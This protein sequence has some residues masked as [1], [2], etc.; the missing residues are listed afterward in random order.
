MNERMGEFGGGFQGR[1]KQNCSREI[2]VK[3]VESKGIAGDYQE[4]KV[5]RQEPKL[6][7]SS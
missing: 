1:K 5:S 6:A 4:E 3:A 2:S 7:G